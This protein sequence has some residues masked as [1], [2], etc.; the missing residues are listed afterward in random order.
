MPWSQFTELF[1]ASD[2]KALL[3]AILAVKPPCELKLK[4]VITMPIPHSILNNTL[5][6]SHVFVGI[7]VTLVTLSI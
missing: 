3:G 1:L 4:D 7:L 2:Q 5:G 6:E